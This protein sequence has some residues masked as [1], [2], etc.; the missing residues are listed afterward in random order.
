M[1]LRINSMAGLQAAR[2]YRLCILTFGLVDRS[3]EARS[4]ARYF[5]FMADD[6]G[7]DG[8]IVTGGFNSQ[9]Q[10][11]PSEF[12]ERASLAI[13]DVVDDRANGTAASLPSPALVA[14][15]AAEKGPPEVG[16]FSIRGL[17]DEGIIAVFRSIKEASKEAGGIEHLSANLLHAKVGVAN[18]IWESLQ[19]KPSAFGMG[20]DLKQLIVRSYDH[21]KKRSRGGTHG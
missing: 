12:L 6:L 21:V 1:G 2:G 19:I 5:D 20:V 10:D 18:A 14:F 7:E 3:P 9:F 17:D 11:D 13:H 15:R 16:Y 8:M 4:V